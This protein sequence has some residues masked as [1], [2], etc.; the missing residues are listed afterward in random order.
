MW[1]ELHAL[2]RGGIVIVAAFGAILLVG[3][4]LAISGL[5]PRGD[6]TLPLVGLCGVVVGFAIFVAGIWIDFLRL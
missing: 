1:R 2:M 5:T 6:A 3:T 4:G